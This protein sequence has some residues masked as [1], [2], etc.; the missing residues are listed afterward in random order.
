MKNFLFEDLQQLQLSKKKKT[1]WFCFQL[2]NTNFYI[3]WLRHTVY[4]NHYK[5]TVQ[6]INMYTETTLLLLLTTFWKGWKSQW[7]SCIRISKVL[8][9]AFSC[10]KRDIKETTSLEL[11]GLFIDR[12][13]WPPSD[14]FDLHPFSSGCK[15]VFVCIS[16]QTQTVNNKY[17]REMPRSQSLGSHFTIKKLV[18]IP[19][20]S[21]TISVGEL[22]LKIHCL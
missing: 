6:C 19:Q 20:D 4:R 17:S 11:K 22:T 1:A 18:Q 12:D 21:K 9:K 16:N 8:Y 13:L 5:R 2:E 3:K 14:G 7:H 10:I 15:Y